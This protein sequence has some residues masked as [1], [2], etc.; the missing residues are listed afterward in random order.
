M[1][2]AA[3]P[4]SERP[5]AR[6]PHASPLSLPHGLVSL[7]GRWAR[8]ASGVTASAA[9]VQVAPSSDSGVARREDASDVDAISQT[10]AIRRARTRNGGAPWTRVAHSAAAKD[11]RSRKARHDTA[12]R[13]PG[14]RLPRRRGRAPQLRGAPGRR[15]GQPRRGPSAARL[16]SV[17]ARGGSTQFAMLSIPSIALPLPSRE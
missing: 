17:S 1:P 14:A 9:C 5:C 10:T 13:A 6:S 4:T 11:S 2:P 12:V 8:R 7:G 15:R 16:N 3:V